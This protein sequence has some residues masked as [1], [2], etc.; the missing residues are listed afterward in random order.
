MPITKKRPTIRQRRFARTLRDLRRAA[1]LKHADAAEA[2]A[3]N[4]SKL[5]RLE[6]AQS[7]IRLVDLRVL[8]DL[9]GVTDPDER[10]KIEAMA[11]DASKKGWW[12]R[13]ESAVDSAYA[14]YVALESDASEIYN[15]ET[16]LIP[17]LLQTPAY[18]EAAVRLQAPEASAEA[19]ETQVA[20][21]KER[22]EV[23][24]RAT[25]L[26]FWVILAESVLYHEVGGREVMKE[27]LE[28]LIEASKETNIEL[29]ILRRE[30][31]LNA[32]L[33]GPY[34]IMSFPDPVESDIAYTESTRGALYYD[35]APDV[36]AFIKLF[37]RLNAAAE[38]VDKSRTLI[39]RALTRDGVK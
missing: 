20:V 14:A 11:R 21:R 27:Q 19:I 18:T 26:Q 22:R 39:A 7:G 33:F 17:G 29:Q 25:P 16:S 2:L 13:Y 32:C 35:E 37:R 9:Y 3:C 30:S 15:V 12:T 4:E 28:F 34:V 38:N 36:E 5:T 24:R 8:L 6:N 1:G 10:V 31:P 23:L